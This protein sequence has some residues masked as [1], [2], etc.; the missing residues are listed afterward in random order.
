M[1][2]VY[3]VEP[4]PKET[5]MRT[6]LL[7]SSIIAAVTA[8]A[9]CKD[10]KPTLEAVTDATMGYEI[11][12]PKGASVLQK[13]AANHT[14]SLP[15]PDGLNELNVSLSSAQPG[16]LANMARLKQDFS[17]IK[18]TSEKDVDGGKLMVGAPGELG[19]QYVMYSKPGRNIG[20]LVT[21]AGPKSEEALL[22]EMCSSLKVTK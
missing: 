22:T 15:L 2:G 1:R 11:K 19:I 8:A 12:I 3:D 13:E 16:D 4:Q 10:K 18:V 21:C 5:A 7:M 9:G 6:L 14:Y 20:I 17:Q